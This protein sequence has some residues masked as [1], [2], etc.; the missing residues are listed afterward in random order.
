MQDWDNIRLWRNAQMDI[1]RQ[2][3]PIT[4][5]QQTSYA[6]AYYSDLKTGKYDKLLFSFLQYGRLIGY[7]GLAHIDRNNNSAETS[8][9]L[10]P[11]RVKDKK[12]YCKE[13][14]TFHQLLDKTTEYMKLHRWQGETFEFRVWHIHCLEE[15]G[16][17][18][19]GTKKDAV[20]KDGRYLD[21]VIH[22][23]VW[24]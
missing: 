16:F 8:F 10:E 7:G 15:Y 13:L 19:E 6:N 20:R 14:I 12:K 22:G 23:K 2:D 11:S 4:T 3:K 9:L 24:E 5:I 21:V 1:L 17:S 18:Y